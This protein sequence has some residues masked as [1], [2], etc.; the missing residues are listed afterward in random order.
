VGT[1]QL[2]ALTWHHDGRLS[3]TALVRY[4]DFERPAKSA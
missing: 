1:M 2:P 4:I 3:L